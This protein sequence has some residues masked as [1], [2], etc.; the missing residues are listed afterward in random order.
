MIEKIE[1]ATINA[2][3]I[4]F[5]EDVCEEARIYAVNESEDETQFEMQFIFSSEK[6]LQSSLLQPRFHA[7]GKQVIEAVFSLYQEAIEQGMMEC[8]YAKEN[9]E[10][11]VIKVKQMVSNVHQ[12]CTSLCLNT[13]KILQQ[14][15]TVKREQVTIQENAHITKR[16]SKS[17][18]TGTNEIKN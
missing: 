9:L 3:P 12:K 16:Y 15:N 4:D 2:I 13:I 14:V 7:P 11:L 10:D 6:C 1:T 5:E 8:E 17:K 18:I